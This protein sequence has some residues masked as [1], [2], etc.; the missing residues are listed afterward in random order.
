M[1]CVCGCVDPW[2]PSDV[3]LCLFLYREAGCDQIH[4]WSEKREHLEHDCKRHQY[5]ELLV[6]RYREK[7]ALAECVLNCGR[8]LKQRELTTHYLNGCENRLIQCPQSDCNE[9]IVCKTLPDHL[10]KDCK[11]LLLA[12]ERELVERGRKRLE[13]RE[14]VKANE[15]LLLKSLE[16]GVIEG[17]SEPPTSVAP[18]SPVRPSSRSNDGKQ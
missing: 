16:N 14:V 15:K 1:K 8:V 9:T 18:L 12:R 5:K 17:K 10:D 13:D 11:S 7:E 4:K 3:P 2:T 6:K